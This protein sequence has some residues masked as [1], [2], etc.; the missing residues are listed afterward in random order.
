MG[1]RV[2]VFRYKNDSFLCPFLGGCRHYFLENPGFGQ[3]QGCCPVIGD[4]AGAVT[5]RGTNPPKH[6]IIRA[7]P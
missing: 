3:L 6:R 4:A 5:E 1:W 7:F 2:L